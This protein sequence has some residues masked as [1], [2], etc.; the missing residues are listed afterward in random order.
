[1]IKPVRCP[2]CKGTN[3]EL[4]KETQKG[5]EFEI[6]HA[7]NDVLIGTIYMEVDGDWVFAPE[8]RDGCWS[9][10]LMKAIAES[11][12]RK[13]FSTQQQELQVA[14][15]ALELAHN[16]ILSGEENK[17]WPWSHWLYE[18]RKELKL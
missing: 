2:F 1:M 8:R 3:M 17:D 5:A 6:R 11:L 4:L 14:L 10:Y 13:N 15:K 7:P 12:E 16:Y 18:A 9:S